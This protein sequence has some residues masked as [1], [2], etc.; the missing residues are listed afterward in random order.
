MRKLELGFD[1]TLGPAGVLALAGAP[2]PKL[3][4]FSAGVLT[5]E[6]AIAIASSAGFAR[7]V[8]LSASGNALTDAAARALAGA[9][10]FPHLVSLAF[11]GDH[12]T[13]G[14]VA[15]L[16]AGGA[17][18]FERLELWSPKFTASAVEQLARWPALA[19]ATD[20]V[21]GRVCIDERAAR[22][23]AEAP[24]GALKHLWLREG[25]TGDAALLALARSE[26]FALR[27]LHVGKSDLTEA[28]LE[29]LAGSPLFARAEEVSLSVTGPNALALRRRAQEIGGAKLK[30]W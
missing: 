6:G 24:F 15:A 9:A 11:G 2:W 30:V 22:A 18:K 12:L 1:H 29:A 17:P 5:D 4:T 14:A 16:V 26:R 20:L 27:K 28:G 8:R 21:L 3:D 23:L 13:D 7:L 25:V 10:F 19:G